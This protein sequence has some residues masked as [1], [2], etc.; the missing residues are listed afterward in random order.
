MA[1]A[2]NDVFE[3]LVTELYLPFVLALEK[4]P[5]LD[6]VITTPYFSIS[7]AELIATAS[8]LSLAL[9]IVIVPIRLVYRF[10]KSFV[11]A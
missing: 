11:K 2:I 7:I 3:L 1:Q 5:I 4:F 6:Q 10:I 8:I 9:F